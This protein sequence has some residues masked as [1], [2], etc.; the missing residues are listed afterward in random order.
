MKKAVA[1]I[2]CVMAIIIA[3][4]AVSYYFFPGIIVKS[5][6]MYNRLSAGLWRHEIQ[7]DDHRWT[8]LEK[9]SGD[10]IIF[11]HGYGDSKEGWGAFPAVFTDRYRVIIPDLPGFG[12]NFRIS[13]DSYRVPDQARRLDRFTEILGVRSFHLCGE[14]MGGTI[15]AYYAT[16]HP[17]KVKS[18]MIMGAPGLRPAKKSEAMLAYEK[19]KTEGLYYKTEKGFHQ[20]M[21]WAFDKPPQFP[22]PF[23]AYFVETAKA[24][25]SFNRKVFEDI[26]NYDFTILENRLPKI[27]APV[28]II[29]GNNDRIIHPSTGEAIHRGLKESRYK[30]LNGGHMIY[31]DDPVN[32]IQAYR[33]FLKPVK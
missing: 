19:D 21:E 30:V 3:G 14:S 12:E 6:F 16:V 28:L 1:V 7:V 18:L 23:V 26:Y 15:A 4:S 27:S 9:G 24:R 11:L 2:I 10:V 25:Y 20:L 33:D 31:A 5:F 29:W 13:T 17:D 22:K 32:T 8:Y